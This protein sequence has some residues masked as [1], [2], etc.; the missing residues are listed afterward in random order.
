MKWDQL[1]GSNQQI[2]Q[3]EKDLD[4][5]DLQN[6]ERQ[7]VPFLIPKYCKYAWRGST[8]RKRRNQIDL[9][10]RQVKKTYSVDSNFGV[11]NGRSMA[12]WCCDW[13]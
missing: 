6:K 9:K 11:G 8:K 10:A 5:F 4:G 1:I 7:K 13:L 3:E 12:G 2:S